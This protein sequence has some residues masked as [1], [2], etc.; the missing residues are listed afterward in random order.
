ML[1][2][3]TFCPDGYIWT[4]DAT[5]KFLA[6]AAYKQLMSDASPFDHSR[7]VWWPSILW[8]VVYFFG[9]Y[10]CAHCLCL[11]LCECG[12]LFILHS[13]SFAKYNRIL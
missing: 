4:A 1:T 5:G 12:K 8:V 3:V 11:T 7:Y 10:G 2:H 6:K 13:V 9:A